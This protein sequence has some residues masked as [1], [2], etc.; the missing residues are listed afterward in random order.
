MTNKTQPPHAR[1]RKRSSKGSA[2]RKRSLTIGFKRIR[3]KPSAIY[4]I[5]WYFA[6]ERHQ[7]YLQRV[8]GVSP[9]WTHDPVLQNYKFTNSFRASDRVSQ[10][11]IRQAYAEPHPDG[12]TIFLRTILFKL[13]NR[14]DTWEA[15]VRNLG[16]PDTRTFSFDA[17]ETILDRIRETKV[18]IYSAAYIMPTGGLAGI[19]KHRMHLHLVRRMIKDQ[20]P[21]RLSRTTSL[22]NAYE[23]LLQYP[24]F[25]P[26]LSFQYAIDLNYTTLMNHSEGAFVVAGPGAL[27]GLSKCFETLGDY[28]PDDTILW[29]TENQAEEFSKYN[30]SF[31][32]LWG[33][34]LQPIDMQNVLCEVSKYTR[35][36]HPE[37]KGISKR[38]RIK[39]K[40]QMTGSL[41]RPFFPPK[42]E[43]NYRVESWLKERIESIPQSDGVQETFP[44]VTLAPYKKSPD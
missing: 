14:I 6:S 20:L 5:L 16:L 11:L 26:F 44:F 43:L 9:P 34:P 19:P 22:A 12:H 23:L 36:T 4:P 31:N 41:A 33:R 42:W 18:P 10:Y 3:P 37:L 13:F 2:K 40:F 15:I 29:L 38:T 7:I 1:I 39:Q 21:D 27:D 28:S 8:C 24:T 17:C 35:A 32:G 30:I 25:G